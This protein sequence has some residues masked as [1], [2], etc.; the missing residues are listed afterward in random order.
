MPPVVLSLLGGSLA[1]CDAADGA[2]E[3]QFVDGVGAIALKPVGDLLVVGVTGIGEGFKRGIEARNAPTVLRWGWP[4]ASDVA[5]IG[6][7]SGGGAHIGDREPVFPVV[8][9]V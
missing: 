1:R 7:G 5:R 3:R 6:D 8:P 9:Q 4:L 2:L